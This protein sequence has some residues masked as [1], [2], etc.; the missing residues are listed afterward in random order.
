LELERKLANFMDKDEAI[1][2][3]TGFSVNEGVLGCHHRPE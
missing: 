1:V 3:P 2:F